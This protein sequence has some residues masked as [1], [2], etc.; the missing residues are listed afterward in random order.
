MKRKKQR[1]ASVSALSAKSPGPPPAVPSLLRREW[2]RAIC[3]LA[4]TFIAYLP[5]WHAGFIIDD[6]G[7]LKDNPAFKG[8][9]TLYKLWCTPALLDYFPVTS[10]LFWLQWLCWGAN[11]LGY[12]LV[13][14]ILHAASALLLWRVF[15]HLAIPGAW[16]AAAL[17]ALHPV[18]VESVAWIAEGKNTLAMFFYAGSLLFWL[19]FDEGGFKRC[20]WLSLGAFALALLSKTAVAPLPVVLLGLAWWRRGRI[21]GRDFW[22]ILPFFMMAAGLGVVTEWF[23]HFHAGTQGTVRTDSFAGRLSGAGLAVWFYLYKVVW[24]LNLAFIYPRWNID[25]S[26]AWNYLPLAFL[27]TAF[28]LCWR[29]RPAWGR[30]PLFGL[31]YFV[32][33]LL[34]VLGFLNIYFMFY[35]LVADH[36]V[37]FA[38]IGPMALVATVLVKKPALAAALL[39]LLGGLTWKQCGLYA[40]PEILWR[41]TLRQNPNCWLAWNDLG[42]ILDNAGHTRDAITHYQKA[43]ALKPDY[44]DAHYNLGN[45]C[46]QEGQIDDA[47]T[48]YRKALEIDDQR[49]EVHNNLA[50]L[51]LQQGKVDEAIVHYKKALAIEPAYAE[52]CLNLAAALARKGDGAGAMT[53][54]RKAAEI[55]P[56]N[57]RALSN[58]AWFLATRPEATPQDATEAVALARRADAL[59]AGQNPVVLRTLAAA[60]ARA[61]QQHDAIAAAQRAL[62]LAQAAGQQAL[63]GQLTEELKQYQAGVPFHP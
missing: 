46:L 4:A 63:A 34:P 2:V 41:E 36:W 32:V 59:S 56:D 40:S 57:P 48:Q 35:S 45:A 12:H 23:I 50:N 8:G 24:P 11:P 49:A 25:P 10:T 13:N 9:H 19:K 14:V 61:G 38:I 44:A 22:P 16:L 39:V 30:A 52:S 62:A 27:A 42:R 6:N 29:M 26:K 43:L 54:F 58:L 37:Y 53:F 21:T 47:E 33:M 1:P 51:L 18:N 17:F 60:W 28:L 55:E 20:Y 3:L 5:V 7:W 31:A 15:R